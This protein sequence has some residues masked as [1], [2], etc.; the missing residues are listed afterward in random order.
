M[1]LPA[2]VAWPTAAFSERGPRLLADPGAV[3]AGVDEDPNTARVIVQYRSGSTLARLAASVG[4]AQHAARLGARLALPLA[5]GRPL[6]PHSQGLHGQGL[7]SRQL[8][9]RLSAQPDVEWAVV[10]QRRTITAAL[11]NDPY[12]GANQTSITPTVGQ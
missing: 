1:L 9:A 5:D 12:Y 8:A 3:S 2:L 10:D 11:P 6:G 4:R 7:S